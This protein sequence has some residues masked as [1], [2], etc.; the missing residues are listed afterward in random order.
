VNA[1]TESLEV[2]LSSAVNDVAYFGVIQ[3]DVGL[4]YIHWLF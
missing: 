1:Q 3:T 2:L 4:L